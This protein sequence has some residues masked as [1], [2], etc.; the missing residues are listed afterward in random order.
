MFI[1]LSVSF[2]LTN[3]VLDLNFNHKRKLMLDIC[4]YVIILTKYYKRKF[5]VFLRLLKRNDSNKIEQR[6][7]MDAYFII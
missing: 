5:F 2:E 4:V 7:D 3:T 6:P 1:T